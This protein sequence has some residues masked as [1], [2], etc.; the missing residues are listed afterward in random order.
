MR[1]VRVGGAI[2]RDFSA[3][4]S[5]LTDLIMVATEARKTPV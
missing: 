5:A 1:F 4:I 3:S 2:A